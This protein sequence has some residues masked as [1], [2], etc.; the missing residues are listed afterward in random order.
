VMGKYSTPPQNTFRA[1][2]TAKAGRSI[3]SRD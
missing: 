2:H 3:F 1:M